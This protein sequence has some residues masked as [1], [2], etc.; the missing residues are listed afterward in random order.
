M[1]D[2]VCPLIQKRC[3]QLFQLCGHDLQIRVARASLSCSCRV[4]RATGADLAG[5]NMSPNILTSL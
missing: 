3:T 4:T 2:F 5:V 1:H